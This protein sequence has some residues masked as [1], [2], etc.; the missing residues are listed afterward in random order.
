MLRLLFDPEDGGGMFLR[1]VLL[2]P[3]YKVLKAHGT[4]LFKIRL[5]SLLFWQPVVKFFLFPQ[6]AVV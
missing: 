5:L 2:S 3:N 6:V 1:K 4:V